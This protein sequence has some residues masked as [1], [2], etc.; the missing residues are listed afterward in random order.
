MEQEGI[1]RE[2]ENDG[3]DEWVSWRCH[4]TEG[5][6]KKSITW[7]WMAKLFIVARKLREIANNIAGCWYDKDSLKKVLALIE[8]DR[9]EVQ[10]I[11]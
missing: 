3:L 1:E 8:K 9:G 2:K 5:F 11:G 10:S 4:K 7:I 6:N